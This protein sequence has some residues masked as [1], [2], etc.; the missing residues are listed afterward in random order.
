MTKLEAL[1]TIVGI[2]GGMLAV[3]GD[4]TPDSIRQEIN[5]A[6]ATWPGIMGSYSTTLSAF[7]ERHVSPHVKAA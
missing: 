1:S 7:V 6:D 5:K 3:V 2:V 4:S